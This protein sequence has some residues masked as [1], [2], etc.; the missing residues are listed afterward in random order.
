M[1]ND[2]G[3]IITIV[4]LIFI[5]IFVFILKYVNLSVK[6]RLMKQKI[7]NISNKCANALMEILPERTHIIETQKDCMLRSILGA[8]KTED[9]LT[10][11]LV[12]LCILNTLLSG[13]EPYYPDIRRYLMS[14]D[15][16][17][18]TDENIGN[19]NKNQ[20]EIIEGN[21]YEKIRMKISKFAEI[22][23]RFNNSITDDCVPYTG[24]FANIIVEALKN[25]CGI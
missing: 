23:Q 3:Y 8:A 17:N 22:V 15:I 25:S 4:I 11:A 14:N 16:L 6:K 18:G 7:I 19:E 1:D 5:L 12:I 10:S 20:E 9:A 24:Y 13:S 21:S 2:I